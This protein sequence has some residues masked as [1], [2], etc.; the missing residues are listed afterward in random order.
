MA[1]G[2]PASQR[3]PNSRCGIVRFD[4]EVLDFA[5]P[6]QRIFNP[7]TAARHHHDKAAGHHPVT[8]CRTIPTIASACLRV[9]KDR[10]NLS[11]CGGECV[12]LYGPLDVAF[13][14]RP[15][16]VGDPMLNA[17]Q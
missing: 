13:S 7:N 1:C 3:K 6:A 8:S 15:E 9:A 2:H 17:L 16:P 12:R 4:R 5:T 11:C 14:Q 10:L